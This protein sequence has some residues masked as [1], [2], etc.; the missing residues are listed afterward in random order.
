MTEAQG[1]I[2]VNGRVGVAIPVPY[3]SVWASGGLPLRVRTLTGSTC[4]F[5]DSNLELNGSEPIASA[6]W[7]K[8]A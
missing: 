8:G 2:Q 1:H 4:P 5:E 3:P 7:A 6:N